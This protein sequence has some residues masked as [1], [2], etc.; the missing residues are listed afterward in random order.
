MSNKK[1]LAV[2]KRIGGV[3]TLLCS[4]NH[5]VSIWKRRLCI[6]E[7][8][9][10]KR[11][12]HFSSTGRRFHFSPIR[13]YLFP[14]F[15][16][17]SLCFYFRHSLFVSVVFQEFLQ[18]C[19]AAVISALMFVFLCLCLRKNILYVH[20][21]LSICLLGSSHLTLP[22]TLDWIEDAKFAWHSHILWHCF[23]STNSLLGELWLTR[24]CA[25]SQAEFFE[26]KLPK[27]NANLCDVT[28]FR[29]RVAVFYFIYDLSVEVYSV[30]APLVCLPISFFIELLLLHTIFWNG[31]LMDHKFLLFCYNCVS[32]IKWH[33]ARFTGMKWSRSLFVSG[34]K[35]IFGAP[36][37]KI[38]NSPTPSNIFIHQSC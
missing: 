4:A 28:H 14:L 22:H 37:S 29:C 33:R 5:M 15:H 3:L 34:S 1:L 32:F 16:T 30:S 18:K 7:S 19:I 11:H 21:N 6:A 24:K 13:I 8:R 23:S 27:S 2:H 17:T 26:R 38:P 10:N 31:F 9:F 25:E 35:E 12:S 36:P 20:V